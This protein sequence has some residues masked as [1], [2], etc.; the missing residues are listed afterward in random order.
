MKLLP[1]LLLALGM[2]QSIP[3][4]PAADSLRVW[5]SK[6]GIAI[7]ERLESVEEDVVVLKDAGGMVFL[8][9]PVN[10]SKEQLIE[11]WRGS[12]RGVGAKLPG[13]S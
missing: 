9:S 13:A 2:A 3:A 8:I 12:L 6:E 10:R 7:K 11:R 4:A 1:I 5:T